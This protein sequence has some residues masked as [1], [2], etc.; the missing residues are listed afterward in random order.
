MT[1]R[2][3]PCIFIEFSKLMDLCMLIQMCSKG[4][5]ST[6]G[7]GI[8]LCYTFAIENGLR[9]GEAFSPLLLSFV[10]EYVIRRIKAG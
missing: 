8:H 1:F 5:Y 7:V 2:V 3:P 10:V 9:K 6:V 4:I